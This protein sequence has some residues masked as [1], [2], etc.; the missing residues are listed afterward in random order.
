MKIFKRILKYIVLAIIVI[1]NGALVF[2]VC[3]ADDTSV[4]N[5]IAANETVKSAYSS[6]G[7][8][9]VVE[10]YIVAE[11]MTQNGEFSAY[12]MIYI[13]SAKQL[14]VTVRMNDSTLE[15]YSLNSVDQIQFNLSDAQ[16]SI[17]FESSRMYE[18]KYMYNYMRLVFDNVTLPEDDQ[19]YLVAYIDSTRMA[20]LIVFDSE[21]EPKEY[22][23]SKSEIS[24]LQGK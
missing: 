18:K 6:L 23:L 12:A 24:E 11:K 1:L 16:E 3:M 22:K 21:A 5:K 9:F 14:Q 15:K 4:L 20:G 13:P 19:L 7:D 2:R 17:N 8:D 10:D